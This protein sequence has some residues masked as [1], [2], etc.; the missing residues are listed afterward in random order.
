MNTI[1]A[2]VDFSDATFK[3]LKQVHH[4]AK[5]FGSRVVLLHVVP[6]EPVVVDLGLASPTVMREASA[7][8]VDQDAARLGELRESL[9]KFGIDAVT[10]QM[11]DGSAD[12]VMEE[13]RGLNA[14]LVVMGAHKHGVLYALFV[15]SVTQD[16][17]KRMTCPVLLV[18]AD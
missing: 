13:I 6:M 8:T 14:D 7:K 18:P 12:A 5:A 2:L 1:V 3:V 10:R 4:L 9:A 15:G 17:L 11:T 16:V